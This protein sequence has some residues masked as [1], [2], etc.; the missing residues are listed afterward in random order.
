MGDLIEKLVELRKSRGISV[1]MMAL[2]TGWKPHEIRFFDNSRA[3]A[4]LLGDLIDY[5]NAIGCEL[6]ISIKDFHG[7]KPLE[8]SPKSE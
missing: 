2:K 7:T 6:D 4:L 5:A 3:E 1:E 8:I